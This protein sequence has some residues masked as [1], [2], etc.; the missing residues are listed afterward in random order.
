VTDARKAI[1]GFV[2]NVA[3]VTA[4]LVYFG[5]R[6]A[7]TQ[8]A[9]LGIDES[10]L[11]MTTQEYM[12]R[13]VN[14]VISML[15]GV[16]AVGLVIAG[17]D[18]AFGRSIDHHPWLRD[19]WRTGLLVGA[20]VLL[21]VPLVVR[22]GL[23]HVSL[24]WAFVLWPAS[25]G[26]AAVGIWYVLLAL[27]RLAVPDPLEGPDHGAGP[28]RAGEGGA[29]PS[30][31]SV[32]SYFLGVVAAIALFWTASNYAIAVGNDLA[33]GYRPTMNPAVVVYSEQALGLDRDG[34]VEERVAGIA[35]ADEQRY[36]FR[37]SGMRLLEH[38]GGTYFLVPE[39]WRPGQGTV[40]M[41]ADDDDRVRFEIG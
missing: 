36:R 12:L 24:R 33:D 35:P 30:A 32:A 27:A 1:V 37:Y 14:P 3:V 31:R 17:I 7:E 10:V 26:V 25:I 6:R 39:S 2:A 13:S 28:P 22:F 23:V 34:V 40:I 15:V 4:L 18:A 19:R 8:A 41:L 21:A 16:A 11:G 38:T 29:L 20:G 9:Q 5:W